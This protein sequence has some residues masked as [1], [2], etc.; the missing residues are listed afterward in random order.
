MQLDDLFFKAEDY[1]KNQQP[2]VLYNKPQ[3]EKVCGVFQQ[4]QDVIYAKDFTE[5]GFV[6]SPFD[7]L[8][9]TIIFQQ[10]NCD[11]IEANLSGSDELINQDTFTETLINPSS[12][13]ITEHARL[14]NEGIKAI[15][16]TSLEKVVLSR[17][18]QIDT[19][20]SALGIF[21]KLIAQYPTAFTYIWYHP[22]IGLWLGATPETLLSISH[23][24]FKTMA[25]AGTQPYQNT[26][27]V[28]WGFKEQEEQQ[29]VTNSIASALKDDS[30]TLNIG[31]PETSRAGA[32]LHLKSDIAGDFK[33]DFNLRSVLEK[34]HPTPA[35][36]GYPKDL[37]KEFI[38]KNENYS[39]QYYTGFL[40][41][42]NMTTKTIRS[43]T[44]RNLEHSAYRRQ[45]G[46]TNLYVNLRCMKLVDNNAQLFVGGGITADSMAEDEFWETHNKLKTMLSVL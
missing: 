14:V 37:A 29:I 9:K 2:F 16:E 39:R 6:F 17:V 40:G 26:M 24:R 41:E 8:D 20:N 27:N 22:K 28:Q 12:S 30:R 5:T 36:C 23:L 25:L 4:T 35:V 3:D 18:F 45:R 1:H 15:K 11:F 46:I 42:L 19:E 33:T 32:L 43:A 31:E 21:K 44:K 38:L 7:D 10:T 13:S 34:L